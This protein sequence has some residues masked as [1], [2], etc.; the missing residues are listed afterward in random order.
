MAGPESPRLASL[1]TIALEWSSSVCDGGLL[2]ADVDNDGLAEIAIGATSGELA[3]FKGASPTPW[4]QSAQLGS[5]CAL[6]VGPLGPGPGNK[7]V[8]LT[9]EGVAYVFEVS[10]GADGAGVLRESCHLLPPHHGRNPAATAAIVLDVDGD[11]QLVVAFDT[12]LCAFRPNA[13]TRELDLIARWPI[14]VG[15][16]SLSSS[17]EAGGS[18]Q[19][20]VGT[21]EGQVL[22]ITPGAAGVRLL[23]PARSREPAFVLGDWPTSHSDSHRLAGVALVARGRVAVACGGVLAVFDAAKGELLAEREIDE[24]VVGL[25]A[26][27]ARSG[28]AAPP[29]RPPPQQLVVCTAGGLVLVVDDCS[30]ADLPEGSS[31]GAARE[32]AGI[33]YSLGCQLAACA[34]G[35]YALAPCSVLAPPTGL[36]A[37][38][39]DHSSPA[40]GAQSWCLAY[41]VAATNELFLA[42]S[43]V[44]PAPSVTNLFELLG[45][46]LGLKGEG[47]DPTPADDLLPR[48]EL[49]A[50]VRAAL[51][52]ARGRR[53]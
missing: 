35:S 5:I 50:L 51:A 37:T 8:A 52:A 22:A 14:P 1:T 36:P 39:D 30:P 19:L 23:V 18:V 42:F 34:A 13:C 32:E 9:A 47:C 48:E 26:R 4:A 20:L 33:C 24:P 2:F 17:S 7:L 28:G 41:T 40:A 11:V 49:S 21:A 29:G 43:T 53:R 38:S 44:M 27:T 31:A 46:P 12:E 6:A 16:R 45:Q 15:A 25:F 3:I 10:T